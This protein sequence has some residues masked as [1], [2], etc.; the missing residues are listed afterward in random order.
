MDE[1]AAGQTN[2]SDAT[3]EQSTQSDARFGGFP[4]DRA[5]RHLSNFYADVEPNARDLS[6]HITRARV[7]MPKSTQ[8]F[9]ERCEHFARTGTVKMMPVPLPG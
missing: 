6:F 4:I 8:E 5:A 1:T 2:T 9:V 3:Q 7:S